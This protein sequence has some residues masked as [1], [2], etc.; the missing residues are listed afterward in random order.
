MD[1]ARAKS[2]RV[3]GVIR[4]NGV[5]ARVQLNDGSRITVRASHQPRIGDWVVEGELSREQVS[6]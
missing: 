1:K 4:W 6:K 5:S 3:S 2:G